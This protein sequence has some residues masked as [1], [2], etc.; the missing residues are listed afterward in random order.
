MKKTI[1]CI[2]IAA[3]LINGCKKSENTNTAAEDFNTLKTSAIADFVHV[4]ALPGYADLKTKA[5]ALNNAVITLNTATTEANL[6][7]AKLAW[8]DVRST[9]EN[10]EGYL[11]GPV[12]SDEHDPETDTWPVNFVDLEA[13]LADLTHSLSVADIEA[14]TNRALKGYHPIEYVLWGKKLSPQT[15]ATLTANTRQKLYI[16]SLSTALKNQA[17]ALYNSWLSSGGN[18]TNLVLTAGAATNTTFAKKQDVYLAILEGMV[19]ICGEVAGG[20]MKEPFDA[21]A[22]AA[23]TGAE[24][25]ES[26]FSGNSLIDFKNNIKGA[27][28]VYLGRYATQGKGIA[29]LVKQK[30]IALNNNIIL[31]FEAAI[32]SFDNITVTYEEA[33]VSQRIQC[34]QTMT[35]I[36]SLSTLLD[37]ELRAFIITNITD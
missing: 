30:N 21:E 28:N 4:V 36:A 5:T 10:C 29:D 22:F 27:Y 25:V 26:P 3:L 15:A 16:V 17:D 34:Q 9:W 1:C 18:Y 11:F 20:K 2:A 35:A 8:K 19:G 12:D 24:L 14:L 7:A 31:K 13:L 6:A 23:G 33:I 37:T 32:N